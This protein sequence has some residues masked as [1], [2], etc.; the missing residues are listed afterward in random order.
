MIG[1]EMLTFESVAGIPTNMTCVWHGITGQ[2]TGHGGSHTTQ[3]EE[4]SDA[5]S[6]A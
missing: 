3:C 6:L 2:K 4:S 5:C 1:V